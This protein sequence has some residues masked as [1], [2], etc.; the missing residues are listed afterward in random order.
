MFFRKKKHESLPT[1]PWLKWL[2]LVFLLYV[3]FASQQP[4]S[5]VQ[6]AF[7]A[8]APDKL[9]NAQRYKEGVFPSSPEPAV[10]YL[11]ARIASPP[12]EKKPLVPEKTLP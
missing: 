9:V 6:Q 5:K 8:M 11:K 4:G 10:D 7:K 12:E 2:L 3:F 1:P